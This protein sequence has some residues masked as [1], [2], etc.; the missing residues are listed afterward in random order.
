MSTNKTTNYSF[1][2]WEGND[3]VQRVEFN[4]NFT[5]IDTKLKEN[6]DAISALDT[7]KLDKTGGVL[8][9]NLYLQNDL[10]GIRFKGT[11]PTESVILHNSDPA[12]NQGLALFNQDSA[13]TISGASKNLAFRPDLQSDVY[14]VLHK[15]MLKTYVHSNKTSNGT[16]AGSTGAATFG[17]IV[18]DQELRDNNNEYVN[19]VFTAKE[20]GVYMFNVSVMW[21]ITTAQF[22]QRIT[23]RLKFHSANNTYATN[24]NQ[25][26]LIGDNIISKDTTSGYFHL[27]TQTITIPMKAGDYVL[28]EGGSTVNTDV[29]GGAVS[30]GWTYF[31][32]TRL[33]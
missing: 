23:S 9:G 4:E 30:A 7:K 25:H 6:A 24:G 15:G 16:I 27:H 31:I 5:A 14:E 21:Y 11:F 1:H 18:F 29:I 12:S 32:A 17:T 26:Y 28:V 19:S 3:R 2:S 22:G 8:T 13:L 20:A 33:N 10:V